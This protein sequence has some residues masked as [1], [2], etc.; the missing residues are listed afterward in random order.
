MDK[1]TYWYQHSVT[2]SVAHTM[3]MHMHMHIHIPMHIHKH[4]HIHK[5]I[6]IHTH[7]HTSIYTSMHKDP[8]DGAHAP[9]TYDGTP[10]VMHD[11][12]VWCD[13]DTNMKHEC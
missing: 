11:V 6:H 2:A 9:C 10:W 13:E 3:R 5:H 8:E 7:T 1:Q 12:A 4:Q